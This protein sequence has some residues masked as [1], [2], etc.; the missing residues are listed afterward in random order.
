[1]N[2]E[3]AYNQY[4]LYV[5]VKQKN[6]SKRSLKEVFKNHILP[7][8]KDFNIYDITANDFILWQQRILT[9]DYKYSYLKKIYYCFS[10]FLEYCINF[11]D[12]KYN[13]AKNNSWECL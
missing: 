8:W 13:V 9:N 7:Y 2:F 12:L 1:M 3:E 6:Q 5:D 11:H 4:M 10:G